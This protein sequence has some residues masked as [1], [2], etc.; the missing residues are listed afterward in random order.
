MQLN[1]EY[2]VEKDTE[3]YTNLVYTFKAYEHGRQNPKEALLKRLDPQLQN[4]ITS[5]DSE[6][7]AYD[8]IYSYLE[9]NCQNNNEKIEKYITRLKDEWVMVGDTII[10]SLEFLYQNKFPFEKVTVY[11]TTNNIFPY[12]YENKYFYANLEYLM[13]QL[14]TAKHELNHF[15]FYYYYPKLKEQLSDEKYELL[16]ES[17]TFF[18]NPEQRGKP[19]ELPLRELYKSKIW[20]N[21]D[22]AV[23]AGVEFL[24]KQ[25]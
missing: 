6:K 7:T 14:G 8:G 1:V 21:M 17:L 12:S 3:T 18:S 22:E 20:K 19:N 5:A 2:S 11:L 24:I 25:S 10:N 23:N 16:K 9:K 13:P 4:I 15:M